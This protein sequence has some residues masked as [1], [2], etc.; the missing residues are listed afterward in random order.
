MIKYEARENLCKQIFRRKGSVIPKAL[1]LAIPSA[2]LSALLVIFYDA[3]S[4]V[5]AELGISNTEISII[6]ST[7]S[8]PLVSLLA[9]RTSQAVGRFWEGTSLL[10]AMRGEW[11]DSASC[12]A[13]FSSNARKQ[14]PI[15]VDQFRQTLLR[16]MSL[17]HGSALDEI[18]M[19]QEEFFEA[20]DITGLD[21][22]TLKILHNCKQLGFNR[23]EVLLHMIQVLVIDAM[24]KEIISVPPPILSRVYQTLSR[25]F[26][27]LLNAK[28]IRDTQFPFPCAQLIAVLLMALVF[29]T[30]LVMSAIF[31]DKLGWCIISTFMP[32]FTLLCLNY[33]AAELEM[34]YGIEAND[35]PLNEFQMEMNSSLLM[36][37]HL[38]SDHVPRTNHLRNKTTYED[39]SQALQ[40]NRF[41]MFSMIS[42]GTPMRSVYTEASEAADSRLDQVR[43]HPSDTVLSSLRSCTP[44][45]ATIEE[46][47]KEDVEDHSKPHIH[48]PRPTALGVLEEAAALTPSSGRCSAN[49]LGAKGVRFDRVMTDRFMNAMN[50][51][52]SDKFMSGA[53][54]D[55]AAAKMSNKMS[56]SRE[57]RGNNNPGARVLPLIEPQRSGRA[58]KKGTT[59]RQKRATDVRVMQFEREDGLDFT[60]PEEGT[61]PAVR[62][63]PTAQRSEK[64][65]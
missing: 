31:T 13:T 38:D 28:K 44:S 16:L 52:P 64:L 47:D 57:A 4:E 58:E 1:I 36:L 2:L 63:I 17:C 51:V 3:T 60:P 7:V 32:V 20:L 49:P 40:Q 19:E 14:K 11:F 25:G 21:T 62:C 33:I 59:K 65:S 5:R 22:A 10:H 8:V 39:L 55:T 24:S 30:P 53:P 29:L 6:W 42:Q 45:L 15:E 12:L 48:L 26:V 35:L 54:E 50:S 61:V 23:V 43:A 56:M 18:K 41:S 34:P 9:Y 27:N 46:P 37:I